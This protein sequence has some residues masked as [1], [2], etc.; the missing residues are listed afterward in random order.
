[1]KQL[2]IE[3]VNHVISVRFPDME[4]TCP[5]VIMLCYIRKTH[6]SFQGCFSQMHSAAASTHAP[7]PF[8]GAF[9]LIVAIFIYFLDFDISCSY[10]YETSL[11]FLEMV[12][13]TDMSSHI[14]IYFTAPQ[15]TYLM[16]HRGI[17]LFYHLKENK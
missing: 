16:K 7:R 5:P 9:L 1:M 4:F 10:L 14:T 8:S 13:S 3:P 2:I 11:P 17:V 6:I 15:S 12:I